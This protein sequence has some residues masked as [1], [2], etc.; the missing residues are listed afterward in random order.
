MSNPVG[1]QTEEIQNAEFAFF[2]VHYCSCF[3]TSFNPYHEPFLDWVKE[4]PQ[5]L[6]ARDDVNDVITSMTG[7][8]QLADFVFARWIESQS[9]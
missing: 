5:D 4:S 2:L 8:N 3:E 7:E 9:T 1:L 6:L